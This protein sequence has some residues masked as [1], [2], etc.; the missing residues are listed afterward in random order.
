M[1]FQ[2]EVAPDID[3]CGP[4]GG[5]DGG[6]V[7]LKDNGWP[8]TS[9]P[10][11]VLTSLDPASTV[12]GGPDFTLTV[13]GTDFANNSVVQ[14]AGSPRT[15]TYVN[16]TQLTAAISAT[17]ILITG[18]ASVTVYNPDDDSTSNALNFIV[19]I[20]RK[21]YLPAISKRWPP[22]PDAPTLNAINNAGSGSY[23]VSWSTVDL[24]TSYLLQEATNAS[25]TSP[26]TV[27][28]GSGTSWSAGGK[29]AGT[30]Y[31]R[32]KASNSYGDSGWSNTQSAQVVPPAATVYV[33]NN[34]GGQLCYEV[35]GSGIGNK[36]YSSGLG[37]YG[38]FPAGT[39]SWH[40][41]ARCGTANGTRNYS[42]GTLTY[43]FTCV[44]ASLQLMSSRQDK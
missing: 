31:Y 23:N 41:S 32:V 33:Q 36:C 39:Y 13:N 27:Y 43:T 7:E 14:W 16:S 30:Y 18:T 19:G 17:D 44:A 11:P 2:E 29:S 34:T 12:P 4:I 42:P 24:A 28:S 6:G 8:D 1:L 15:T 25:F 5:D 35:Y 38:T 26:T 10:A 9:N 21:V 22:I 40:A 37:L 3:C 20:P